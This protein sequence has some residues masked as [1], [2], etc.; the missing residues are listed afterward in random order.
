LNEIDLAAPAAVRHFAAKG[1]DMADKP[2]MTHEEQKA[3]LEKAKQVSEQAKK[4]GIDTT[5]TDKNLA[6]VAKGIKKREH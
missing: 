4:A 1:I 5:K 6:D 2:K 3:L